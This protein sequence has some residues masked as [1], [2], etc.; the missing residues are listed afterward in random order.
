MSK[1]RLDHILSHSPPRNGFRVSSRCGNRDCLYEG[2]TGRFRPRPDL[3]VRQR[4]SLLPIIKTKWKCI[5]SKI[6]DTKKLYSNS[7]VY[8]LITYRSPHDFPKIA[9]LYPDLGDLTPDPF[10]CRHTISTRRSKDLIVAIAG[11]S[12]ADL[13]ENESIR[14]VTTLGLP[15]LA[16]GG[17]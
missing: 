15:P 17:D 1:V 7:R 14:L 10:R 8:H 2:E 13:N 11:S 6:E 9:L 4:E 16:Q 3:I 12:N 5:K